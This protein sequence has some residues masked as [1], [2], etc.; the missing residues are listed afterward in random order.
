MIVS[1]F[2]PITLRLSLCVFGQVIYIIDQNVVLE[3]E[4]LSAFGK[5]T[6]IPFI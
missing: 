4:R 5:K 6:E 1:V 2:I 3:T